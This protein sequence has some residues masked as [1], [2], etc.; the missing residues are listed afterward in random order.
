MMAIGYCDNVVEEP[1]QRE[2]RLGLTITYVA[3]HRPYHIRWRQHLRGREYPLL[4]KSDQL[5]DVVEYRQLALA[6]FGVP[7]SVRLAIQHT[8]LGVLDQPVPHFG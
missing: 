1:T 3:I 6:T 4:N 2:C 5:V 7:K 8:S